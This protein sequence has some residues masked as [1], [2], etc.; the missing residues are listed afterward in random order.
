MGYFLDEDKNW[1]LEI[2]ELERA[3]KESKDKYDTRV[4]CV[5][6]PGNPTGMLFLHSCFCRRHSFVDGIAFVFCKKNEN[7]FHC[8]H[9][10][11]IIEWSSDESVSS[12]KKKRKDEW[13]FNSNVLYSF[14]PQ[15]LPLSYD[16]FSFEISLCFYGVTKVEVACICRKCW[17]LD[18]ALW[19]ENSYFHPHF[20][21][22]TFFLIVDS[23][24]CYSFCR[25]SIDVERNFLSFAPS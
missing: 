23:V 21:H 7:K 25:Q 9:T 24:C 16:F 20:L 14:P 13:P 19:S 18:V 12:R 22:F 11:N 17:F 15:K 3:L 2:G 4:L 5:I 8:I 10:I 6:N 1:A